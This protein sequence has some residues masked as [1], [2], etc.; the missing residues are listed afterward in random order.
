MEIYKKIFTRYWSGIDYT[1]Y[2]LV[3]VNIFIFVTLLMRFAAQRSVNATQTIVKKKSLIKSNEIF[4]LLEYGIGVT[5]LKYHSIISGSPYH[6]NL[7]IIIL[8]IFL[9]FF[10]YF[11]F[12]I[13]S[14][15][16][17]FHRCYNN[18]IT[19]MNEKMNDDRKL[20]L[21]GC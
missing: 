7:Y 18:N 6:G 16:Y 21:S 12:I 20:L 14:R 19:P 5:Y 8:F 2:V 15:N 3:F 10:F 4:Y 17:N 1:L 9:Y 11:F 13:H